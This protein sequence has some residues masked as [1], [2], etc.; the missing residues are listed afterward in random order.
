MNKDKQD[1]IKYR[2]F[3]YNPNNKILTTICDKTNFKVGS[4]DCTKR[5]LFFS[6]IDFIEYYVRCNERR[7][8]EYR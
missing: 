2:Y 4:G 5:C 6:G 8:Y 1:S 3:E 7:K